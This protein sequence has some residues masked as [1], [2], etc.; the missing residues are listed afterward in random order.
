M[1]VFAH[2]SHL[3]LCVSDLARSKRFYVDALGFRELGDLRAAGRE[4]AALLEVSEASLHAVYLERDGLRLELLHFEQPGTT[5]AGDPRAMNA[6]GLTHLSFRV[7]DLDRAIAA[8]EASGGRCLEGSRVEM[9]ALHTRVAFVLDPDG[10]RLELL[11][12]PGDPRAL[13]IAP[14]G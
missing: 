7:T 4:T 1:S 10:T 5:G 8:V 2:L 11:E 12:A 14:S 9:P 3:G 6:P 13:P